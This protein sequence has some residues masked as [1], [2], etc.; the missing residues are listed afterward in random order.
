MQ[1]NSY[2]LNTIQVDWITNLI[3]VPPHDDGALARRDVGA[4]QGKD[5]EATGV[6]VTKVT[7]DLKNNCFNC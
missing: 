7:H 2:K 4:D 5:R 1:S 6:N 3:H